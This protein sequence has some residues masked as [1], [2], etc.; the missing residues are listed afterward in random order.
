MVSLCLYLQNQSYLL[1]M[2]FFA[3]LAWRHYKNYRRV[4]VHGL[5]PVY[6]Q[7]LLGHFK[8]LS[9]GVL[10]HFSALSEVEQFVS[11]GWNFIYSYICLALFSVSPIMR[12][13]SCWRTYLPWCSLTLWPAIPFTFS[14]SAFFIVCVPKTYQFYCNFSNFSTTSACLLGYK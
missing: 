1:S 9:H 7:H 3:K 8:V 11:P 13:T 10:S 14:F 12:F 5:L 4:V 2:T 6:F